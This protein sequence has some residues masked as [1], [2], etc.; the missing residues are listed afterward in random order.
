MNV[1]FLQNYGKYT[2]K[3]KFFFEKILM[4][5]DV[6]SQR[7]FFHFLIRWQL[8]CV[9]TIKEGDEMTFFY[10]SSEWA[11][12]QP[13]TCH[14][15]APECLETIQGAAYLPVKVL[16]KYHLTDF[17]QQKVAERS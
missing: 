5:V 6:S 7:A 10:P 12:E 4:P 3:N 8:V 13:F 1:I 16:E 9:K 11:M 15:G 14:C 17:I 2:S